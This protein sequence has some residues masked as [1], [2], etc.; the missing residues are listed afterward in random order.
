MVNFFESGAYNSSDI[1]QSAVNNVGARPTG[2]MFHSN[3]SDVRCKIVAWMCGVENELRANSAHSSTIWGHAQQLV[4][5][6]ITVFD[7]YDT[8][9]LDC[10]PP[11]MD[12]S[13]GSNGERGSGTELV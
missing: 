1:W 5:H 6:S 9:S 4:R 2:L 10:S 7:Q 3:M 11:S 12:A 13:L 8:I